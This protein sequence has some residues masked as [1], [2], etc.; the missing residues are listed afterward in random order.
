MN[1]TF[2]VSCD[3]DFL[4]RLNKS[5]DGKNRSKFIV[6]AVTKELDRY[7]A[8]LRRIKWL[9]EEVTPKIKTMMK[10]HTF[11]R[12]MNLLDNPEQLRDLI[13]KLQAQEYPVTEPELRCILQRVA[14]DDSR[15]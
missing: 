12:I 8:N 6:D 5:L 9:D 1:T 10:N 3:G 2:P 13:I 4:E 11:G 15:P 7:D 14:N